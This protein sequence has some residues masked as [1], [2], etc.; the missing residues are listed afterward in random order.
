[1]QLHNL[2]SF[3]FLDLSGGYAS[4]TE[5]GHDILLGFSL[6]RCQVNVAMKVLSLV[7]VWGLSQAC[8]TFP[9]HFHY[10]KAGGQAEA[11]PPSIGDGGRRLLY[12]GWLHSEQGFPPSCSIVV[13]LGTSWG[14]SPKPA[15]LHLVEKFEI[16]HKW[17]PWGSMGLS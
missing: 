8:V 4:F 16:N 10:Y 5:A 14:S 9:L 6:E 15:L 12:S 1:M 17:L 3:D 7:A 2:K 11:P 13:F